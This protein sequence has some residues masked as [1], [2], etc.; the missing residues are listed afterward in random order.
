VNA[1]KAYKAKPTRLPFKLVEQ[2]EGWRAKKSFSYK[3]SQDIIKPQYALE[4]LNAALAKKDFY[5]TTDVGQHQMWAAQFLK[6][7]RPQRWLT[8][9]GLGTMDT[10]CR[11]PWAYR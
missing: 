7:D 5:I 10:A 4:R 8:S 9:G 1:W 3:M 6:F 11:R 2:V